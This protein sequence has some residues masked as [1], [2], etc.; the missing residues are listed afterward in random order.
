MNSFFSLSIL[1]EYAVSHMSCQLANALYEPEFQNEITL[2][3]GKTTKKPL[4]HAEAYW[5]FLLEPVFCARRF[6]DTWIAYRAV[7]AISKSQAGKFGLATR[8]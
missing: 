1:V 2:C 5:S 6:L 8:S 3:G 7:N 4:I